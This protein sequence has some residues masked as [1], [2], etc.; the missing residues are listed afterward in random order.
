ME[1]PERRAGLLPQPGGFEGCGPIGESQPADEAA[2]PHGIH[3]QR[4]PTR[5]HTTVFATAAQG[6]GGE[7]LIS[8]VDQLVELDTRVVELGPESLNDPPERLRAA[9]NARKVWDE[10]PGRQK[11]EFGWSVRE[12]YRALNVASV[13]GLEYSPD[14]LHVLLRHRPPSIP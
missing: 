6:E 8:G 1:R 9:L 13:E 12:L 3:A 7:H 4:V 11:L 10:G 14:H 5:L 2:V